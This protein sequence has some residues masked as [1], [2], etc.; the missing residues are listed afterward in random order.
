MDNNRGSFASRLINQV[1]A[2]DV[3]E[4]SEVK[5]TRD[6]GTSLIHQLIHPALGLIILVITASEK[7]CLITL[8]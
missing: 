8:C 1:E 7:A 3:L 6:L 4:V 2:D 5:E